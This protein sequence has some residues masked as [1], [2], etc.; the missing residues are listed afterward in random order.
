MAFA[1]GKNLR[2]N[3]IGKSQRIKGGTNSQLSATSR[4]NNFSSQFAFRKFAIFFFLIRSFAFNQLESV[5]ICGNIDVVSNF[6]E[7]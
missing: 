4:I 7:I 2:R 6:K 3:G 5:V 1:Y